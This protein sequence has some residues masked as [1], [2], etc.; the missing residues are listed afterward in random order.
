MSS[1]SSR[2]VLVGMLA[3]VAAGC[4]SK[5]GSTGST[6]GTGGGQA[7]TPQRAPAADNSTLTSAQMQQHRGPNE[8]VERALMGRFPGVV[9]NQM[10][11]GGF[12]IRIRG[13]TS[14]AQGT[15]PLYIVDGM[16]V[17][18]SANGA[19]GGFPLEDIETIKVLKDAASTSFYGSRGANGVIVITTKKGKKSQ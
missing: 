1:F 3:A 9:V 19:L 8:G 11:D 7:A 6:S 12:T 16:P 4:A 2:A 18:P 14:F 13:A 15:Y 5:G 17:E 10:P